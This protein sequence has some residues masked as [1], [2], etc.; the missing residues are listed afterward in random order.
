M[1][2]PEWS[3]IDLS[4]IAFDASM[5]GDT[6]TGVSKIQRRELVDT[7]NYQWSDWVE[8]DTLAGN[9]YLD[10]SVV[11][12]TIYS[13]RVLNVYSTGFFINI[14]CVDSEGYLYPAKTALDFT[15]IDYAGERV[16][17]HYTLTPVDVQFGFKGKCDID[18]STCSDLPSNAV[19]QYEFFMEGEAPTQVNISLYSQNE[20]VFTI[21]NLGFYHFRARVTNPVVNFWSDWQEFDFE[22]YT[23]ETNPPPTQ[24]SE[25]SSSPI[26]GMVS[27]LSAFA[28]VEVFRRKR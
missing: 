3:H 17:M 4:W 6:E 2:S 22:V 20:V 19:V 1:R 28:V 27:I 21:Y 13:Y 26:F 8:I 25:S 14:K 7:V 11:E 15:V 12:G 5:H 18:F 10:Y 23:P 16:F 9:S 24:T